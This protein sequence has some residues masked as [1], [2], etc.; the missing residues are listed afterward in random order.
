MREYEEFCEIKVLTFTIL[1]NHFHLQ[2]MVPPRPQQLPSPDQ[3]LAKL[4][5]LTSSTDV[6]AIELQIRTLEKNND[7]RGLEAYMQTFYRRMWNLSAFMK[8]LKQRFTQWY[9]ALHGR[10]GTLWESRFRS[11]I[12]EGD[13]PAQLASSAYTDLNPVRAGIVSDPL[14]YRW[15]GYAQAVAGDPRAIEGIR[16]ITAA[17]NN[18]IIPPAKDALSQYRL[19]LFNRGS[20]DHNSKCKGNLKRQDVL[21]VIQ[22]KGQVSISDILKC[23]VR[24]FIDGVAIGSREFVEDLFHYNRDLFGP[25][26][27]SGARRLRAIKDTSLFTLRDLKKDT[28]G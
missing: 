23:R 16:I 26:R 15:C 18:G 10:K 1:A 8:Q 14:D 5:K 13:G 25:N 27:R 22:N 6:D 24:H 3:M 4:R 2:L 20:E 9:N 11:S 12:V 19:L 28:F 21:Q 17:L 7:R